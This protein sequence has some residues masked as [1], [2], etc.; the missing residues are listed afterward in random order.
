VPQRGNEL[1]CLPRIDSLWSLPRTIH[2]QVHFLISF[3][4]EGPIY[5]DIVTLDST[6][7]SITEM[8]LGVVTVPESPP[9]FPNDGLIG[10]SGIY[11][12]ALNSSSW[13]QHLCDEHELDECRFGIAYQTDDTGVQYFGYVAEDR[14]EGPLSV[15]PVPT[16][17]E[18]STFMDVAYDGKVIVKDQ[19]MITD[20]GTTVMFGLV[21][22]FFANRTITLLNQPDLLKQYKPFSMLQVFNQ[23]FI[24]APRLVHLRHSMDIF[25]ALNHRL[26]DSISHLLVMLR[27]LAVTRRVLLVIPVRFSMF[28]RVSWFRIVRETTVPRVFTVLMNGRFG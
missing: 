9:T 13:F 14:F 18:W 19:W 11:Q 28:Y 15:G 6:Q 7:L 25:P 26:L 24:P 16:G 2:L 12:T 20:S 17:F 22:L 27:L 3:Q 5:K 4:I 23:F 21:P 8:P 10:F 1:V